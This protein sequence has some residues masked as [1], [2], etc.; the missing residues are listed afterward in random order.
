MTDTRMTTKTNMLICMATLLG[1]CACTEATQPRRADGSPP[2]EPFD[3]NADSL[4]GAVSDAEAVLHAEN[5]AHVVGDAHVA[6]DADPLADVD[7][8]VDWGAVHD[9]ALR[10]HRY[11]TAGDPCTTEADCP[12]VA[13]A[14]C[15]MWP[16]GYCTLPCEPDGACAEGICVDIGRAPALGLTCLAACEL[17][18]HCRPGY[19]CTG[20]IDGHVCAPAD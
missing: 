17:D 10:P 18:R 3:A 9:A 14:R 2:Q 13:G 11:R 16:G 15:L 7:A 12:A 5:D 19:V 6:S 8:R 20:T 1:A 4:L